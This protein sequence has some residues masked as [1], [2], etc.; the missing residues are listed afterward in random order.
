MIKFDT[1]SAYH[2]VD[3]YQPHTDYLGFAWD[4]ENGNVVYYKYLVLSFGLSSACYIYTKLMR[5]L[6]AKWRGE[7]KKIIMFLD[8]GFGTGG[9]YEKTTVKSREIKSDFVLS[10]LVPNVDKSCWEPVQELQ[11]LGALLNSHEFTTRIPRSRID[12]AR[13]SLD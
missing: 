5:P 2:F 3:I 6:I 1:T 13:Q 9:T 11:W 7:G 4:D 10:G 12:K 8:D